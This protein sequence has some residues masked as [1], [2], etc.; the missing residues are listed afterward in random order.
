[1][2][3]TASAPGKLVLL[4]EYA[5][6]DGASAMVM[7]VDRR[8]RARIAQADGPDCRLE[9]RM[10][11]AGAQR[12]APG[13]PSRVTLVD[14]IRER[15]GCEPRWRSWSA[16]LDSGPFFAGGRKL[17]LGS[18]AA[19]LVAFSAA[20][21]R[22]AAQPRQAL[23]LAELISLHRHFQGGAGS[24]LDIAAAFSGGTIAFRLDQNGMHQI[25]SVRLP[26]S[27]GFAGIFA[28]RSASTTDLVGL[29][30]RFRA[31]EPASASA[32]YRAMSEIAT[33]GLAAAAAGDGAALVAAVGDYGCRLNALG[34]AM[35]IELMTP[36]HRE[37]RAIA[38][39]F[40]LSYK[41]SGAGGGDMGLACGLDA[42]ALGAF[43]TAV[44][45]AG[46]PAFR[47]QPASQGLLVE[48]QTE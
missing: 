27:V 21:T 10:P 25:G 36:A 37:I 20:W 6:L 17:G 40:G 46:F 12:F 35:R 26:N 5:V 16:S 15:L 14:L 28:G 18:S 34:A 30:Q 22:V 29:Y 2:I 9:T 23:E 42:E 32:L 3:V 39:G 44:G 31:A 43:I 1:M 24:G 7:A 19:A 38:T 13:A 4:G 33:D 45:E 11:T 47:L 41:M 48:E 8:C